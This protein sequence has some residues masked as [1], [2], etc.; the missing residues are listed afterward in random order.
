[1]NRLVNGLGVEAP[2]GYVKMAA[3][4]LADDGYTQLFDLLP[5]PK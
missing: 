4:R 1:M 2:E 3:Q 5:I